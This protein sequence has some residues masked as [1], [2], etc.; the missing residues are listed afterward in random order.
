MGDHQVAAK[1]S[2]G[3]QRRPHPAQRRI[4]LAALDEHRA[5]FLNARPGPPLDLARMLFVHPENPVGHVEREADQRGDRH[6]ARDFARGVAAH[7]VGDDHHVVD[8]LR[9]LRHISR[10]EAGDQRLQRA[11]EPGDE[12]VVLVVLAVMTG[13]R[14]RADIDP[15]ER[16][17]GL[18]SRPTATGVR[19]SKRVQVMG[20][21]PERQPEF[22]G[23]RRTILVRMA[24][25]F[26]SPFV[27]HPCG[28][29]TSQGPKAFRIPLCQVYN[30]HLV[31]RPHVLGRRASLDTT[32]R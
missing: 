10:G 29:G 3:G 11:A 25:R 14:Q 28:R 22:N 27:P 18:P 16:R 21:L 9:A 12:E 6:P 19:L 2:S 8:F 15:D 30:G 24:P 7:A 20:S 17:K 4:A 32:L 23:N 31:K 1:A 26:N 5:D 13:M